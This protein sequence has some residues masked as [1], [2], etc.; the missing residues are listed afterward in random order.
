MTRAAAEKVIQRLLDASE[1]L[2]DT[3]RVVQA[4]SPETFE[5]YRKRAAD[6]MSAIYLDLAKPIVSEYPELDFGLEPSKHNNNGA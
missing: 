5:E 4:E 1:S 3:V 6:V 2:N